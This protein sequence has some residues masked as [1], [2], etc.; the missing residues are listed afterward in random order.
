M[1]IGEKI[2]L[3]PVE[4]NDV[5]KFYKWRNDLQLKKLAMMHPFPVTL[6]SEKEWIEGISKKKDNQLIIF[7]ICEK[8]SNNFIGFVKLFNINWIHRHCY[9]GIVIGEDSTRSKGYGYESLKLISEYAFDVLDIRKILL[10]V[11]E[12]NESAVRLYRKFGFIEE[13]KLKKQFYFDGDWHNVLIM[14]LFK[15]NYE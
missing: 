9:F 10:E 7:S 5:E 8:V 15:K 12:F 13:G 14:S 3:R 11:V 1:L 4:F 2:L 6:E